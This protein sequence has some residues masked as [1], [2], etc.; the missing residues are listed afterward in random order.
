MAI[1]TTKKTIL[2][3]TISAMLTGCNVEV[4]Q[5]D[6]DKF[7]SKNYEGDGVSTGTVTKKENAT[8]TVN[9]IQFDLSAANINIDGQT[10]D[11]NDVKQGQVVTIKATYN[12][13]GTA[14]A[15][16]L[17]YDDSI[18]GPVDSVDAANNRLVVMGQTVLVDT[19][20]I[21]DDLKLSDLQ[22]GD[23]IEVSGAANAKGQW[24]A[25]YLARS[26]QSL[27][28][29]DVEGSI[30]EHDEANQTFKINDLL[31]DYSEVTDLDLLIELLESGD[32]IDFYGSIELNDNGEPVL[33]ISELEAEDDWFTEEGDLRELG[34]LITKGIANNQFEINGVRITVNDETYYEFG[35]GSS[36]VLDAEVEVE[37]ILNEDGSITAMYVFVEPNNEHELAAKIQS[38][39]LDDQTLTVMG[40]QYRVTEDSL[41]VDIQEDAEEQESEAEVDEDEWT[42]SDED[43]DEYLGD[44]VTLSDLSVGD[45]IEV[46]AY[47]DVS[48]QSSNIM[49]LGRLNGVDENEV[50]LSAQ[51]QTIQP[52]VESITVNGLVIELSAPNLEL[53]LLE[54]N[55][56]DDEF[57]E[58]FEFEVVEDE[59]SDIEELENMTSLSVQDFLTQAEAGSYV[60]LMGMDNS[61]AVTWEVIELEAFE[62]EDDEDGFEDEDD[63]E[64]DDLDDESDS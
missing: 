27:T 31:V 23:I 4:S 53:Y 52:E 9:G 45:F 28:E 11:H 19:K 17:E 8:A 43:Y 50:F 32:L 40:K 63:Y 34:G 29:F 35:N 12:K 47:D 5:E 64:E 56:W 33:H 13:D 44:S 54:Y 7:T 6:I 46:V 49:F 38:I 20:T 10:G 48:N 39:N 26:D 3:A 36:L 18:E 16:E 59:E 37:G 57:A 58:N 55:E 41:L 2:A 51:I 15:S 42:D 22:A 21:L 60:N 30:S 61:G 1:L 14:T 24:L 25:S 62:E